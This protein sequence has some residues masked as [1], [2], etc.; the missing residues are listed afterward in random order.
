M[1]EL[2]FS[3]IQKLFVKKVKEEKIINIQTTKLEEG[4]K[5]LWGFETLKRGENGM[6]LQALSK[7]LSL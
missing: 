4:A 7:G 2:L 3:N 6:K 1:D 5:K